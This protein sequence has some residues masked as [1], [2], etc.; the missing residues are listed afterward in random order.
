VRPM[1]SFLASFNPLGR[2]RVNIGSTNPRD[3][4]TPSPLRPRL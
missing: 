3:A 4:Y 2:G 1:A